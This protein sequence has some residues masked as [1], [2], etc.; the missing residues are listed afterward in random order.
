[1]KYIGIAAYSGTPSEA[2]IEGVREFIARLAEVVDRGKIALVVGGYWGLMKYVVNE[3]LS[4]GFKVIIF[5]P[6]SMEDVYFPKD[7]IVI[8]TGTSFRVRSVFLVRTS[9]I[10]VS[11]GGASGSIQEIVTAYNEGRDVFVLGGSGMATD[12]ISSFSP[13]IDERK[14]S[15]IIMVNNPRKLADEVIKSINR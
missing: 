9:D 4:M 3:G 14:T 10:L 8:K 12:K 15:R 11:L 13:Y 7:A 6:E 2:L 1:M 5:P